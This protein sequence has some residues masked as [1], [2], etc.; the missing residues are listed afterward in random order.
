MWALVQKFAK[1]NVGDVIYNKVR[2]RKHKRNVIFLKQKV[3]NLIYVTDSAGTCFVTI[4]VTAKV[5]AVCYLLSVQM[6]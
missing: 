5:I 1:D 4:T 2:L 6:F 3:I